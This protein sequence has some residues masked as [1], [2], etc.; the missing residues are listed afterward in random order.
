VLRT[1]IF[2]LACAG[3]A[4]FALQ[5]AAAD[6]GRQTARL[7]L[8]APPKADRVVVLKQDRSLVLMQGD[9]VL[10]VFRIALGRYATGPKRREG[11]ARTPEGEY[12]LDFKLQD[13]AFYRAIHISYPNPQ[14][15][16]HA[17]TQ[18]VE[19]G[20]KIMIHGLPNNMSAARVGHPVIDWTQGCI[21]I[22]NREMDILWRMVDEGTPIEIH[23]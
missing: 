20:G 9:R 10:R 4:L 6:A 7:T 1:T 3:V 11:D 21:A 2:R 19:P 15:I 16:A 22:T 5:P 18:G 23:P 14:D 17:R 13:S 12:T 8:P